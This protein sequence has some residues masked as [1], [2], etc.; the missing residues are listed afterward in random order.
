[1]VSPQISVRLAREVYE[2]LSIIA[3]ANGKT[4]AEVAREL[5]NEALVHR[6]EGMTDSQFQLVE[7]R[8][9]YIERR[10][11]GWMGKLSRAIAECLWYTQQIATC[12]LE[13]PEEQ[14]IHQ[15]AQK[16][17]RQFLQMKHPDPRKYEKPSDVA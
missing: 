7:V 13:P 14:M 2:E 10:F 9:G 5:I 6:A 17:V 3:K 8:L 4:Q 15:A 12:E 11:S 1:M 16:F